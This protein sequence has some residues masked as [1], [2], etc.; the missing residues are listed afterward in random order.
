M[1]LGS[2]SGTFG[3]GAPTS[4][5]YVAAA[6]ASGTIISVRDNLAA[7]T[8]YMGGYDYNTASDSYVTVYTRASSGSSYNVVV[9]KFTASTNTVQWSKQL[10]TSQAS[11]YPTIS[12]VT[13]HD[14][15]S[16]GIFYRGTTSS[17]YYPFVCR[18]ASDGTL[19]WQKK[20]TATLANSG[21]PLPS[22]G[23]FDARDANREL[24][25]VGTDLLLVISFFGSTAPM[26][27]AFH[28]RLNGSTGAATW[29]REAYKSYFSSP[30]TYYV[31]MF[32]T[33]TASTPDGTKAIYA[34][35]GQIDGSKYG[36]E[37]NV[38]AA[39]TGGQQTPS[40]LT[41]KAWS[42][43]T[44]AKGLEISSIIADNSYV[45]C[46]GVN[47]GDT[48]TNYEVFLMAVSLSANTVFW[49]RRLTSS[50]YAGSG[51]F[52]PVPY[53]KFI[54]S[55]GYLMTVHLGG[56]QS[57]LVQKWSSDG[58]TVQW[59]YSIASS[60][61]KVWGVHVDSAN[62]L[63][64][65]W[66]SKTTSSA[67]SS[68]IQLNAVTGAWPYIEGTYADVVDNGTIILTKDTSAVSEATTSTYVSLSTG[69]FT[70]TTGTITLA[71]PSAAEST[72]QTVTGNII[73][74]VNSI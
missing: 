17:T 57:W 47:R 70:D 55:G 12:T 42:Q 7:A 62:R 26:N 31:T 18:F 43:T 40:S 52:N 73:A 30:N 23:Y 66:V 54:P 32:R 38:Y 64:I 41:Y 34:W 4:I 69:S 5:A 53:I 56:G 37:I 71:N 8:W 27:G 45:Y 49:K 48:S 59:A 11:W 68:I 44:T 65:Y 33:L 25:W 39:S 14:D 35:G 50:T 46:A 19:T 28:I 58:N 63:I 10:F 60:T 61:G 1:R 3:A 24:A 21:W 6:T 13:I 16:V 36:Q 2:V 22:S 72:L 67:S 29:T 9:T 15:G 20:I 74:T 51:S